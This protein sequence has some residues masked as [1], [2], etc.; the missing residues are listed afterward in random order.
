MRD[1]RGYINWQ[2]AEDYARSLDSYALFMAIRD[3][4]NT[5]KHADERDRLHFAAGHTTSISEGGYYR[6]CISVYRGELKRRE[7]R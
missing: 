4:Q 5:L 3:C 1:E 6:D 7:L 2:R